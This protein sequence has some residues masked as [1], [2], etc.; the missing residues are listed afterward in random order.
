M[1][2]AA[3]SLMSCK[4][5]VFCLKG[6]GNIIT[7]E[8]ILTDF[9]E[10]SLSTSAEV[11][12]TQDE[13]Y[14]VKVE[15]S[16]NLMDVIE[17]EVS[18]PT[19]KIKRKN[20]TCFR[21]NNPIHIYV[22]C[23]DISRFSVSGSGDIEADNLITT[24]ALKVKVSG[25]GDLRLSDL[26]TQELEASVSGSGNVTIFGTDT[27]NNESIKVS[28][29]GDINVLNIPALNA[30]VSVSGSGNCK[31]YAID[32]LDVKIS[33]SGDVVY[34]GNPSINSNVVGSGSLKHL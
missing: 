5:G 21:G 30:D 11:H 31:V 9:S 8:R 28:G 14:S 22:S 24:N 10:I 2:V 18:G 25:S 3:S 4:K 26:A 33:G 27:I 34:K 7:E 12:F 23:P 15:A 17:T 32:N 16:D 1:A 13:E 20:N 29:S 19:L 6:N